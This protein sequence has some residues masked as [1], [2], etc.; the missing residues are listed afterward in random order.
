M[1]FRTIGKFCLLLVIIGF[2]MPMACDMNAF[3]LI[4]KG[5]LKDEG[6]V[7]MYVAFIF[8]IIGVIVGLLLLTR[9]SVPIIADWVVTL[10]VSGVVIVM[11]YH[12]G[13]RQNYK[14]SFQSGVYLALTGAILALIAQ[15][16]SAVKRES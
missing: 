12:I 15:V 4:D 2:L 11:F 14:D 1:S 6:V 8:A 3:Q 5:M 10:I 7:A 16:L 13:Y 9:R